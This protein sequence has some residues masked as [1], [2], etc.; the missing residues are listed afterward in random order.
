MKTIYKQIQKTRNKV[1]FE[2]LLRE[3]LNKIKVRCIYKNGLII[4]CR[5]LKI[6]WLDRLEVLKWINK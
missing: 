2:N 3:S 6:N 1:L 4:K 5:V